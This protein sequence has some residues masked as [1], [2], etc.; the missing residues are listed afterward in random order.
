MRA[1]QPKRRT[2]CCC[3]SL[4]LG[5]MSL[6]HAPRAFADCTQTGTSV[7]CSGTTTGDQA[8]SLPPYTQPITEFTV[9]NGATLDGRIVNTPG[10]GPIV[11]NLDGQ[12][13]TAGGMAIT[14]GD[15]MTLNINTTHR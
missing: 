14:T 13:G 1:N 2:L 8:L 6:A 3:I 5:A 12:A 15:N 4:A 7:R 11:V 10:N 9:E